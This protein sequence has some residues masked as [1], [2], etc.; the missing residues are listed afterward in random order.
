MGKTGGNLRQGM[1]NTAASKS[2][3]SI[4]QKRSGK[5]PVNPNHNANLISYA[6]VLGLSKDE[7]NVRMTRSKAIKAAIQHNLLETASD[8][9]LENLLREAIQERSVEKAD[10]LERI[11][12]IIGAVFREQGSGTTAM[13][14]NVSSND[15]LKPLS[16]KFVDAQEVKQDNEQSDDGHQG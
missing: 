8:A 12:R 6:D 4:Q 10:L 2:R 3:K 15:P 11:C 5:C 9:G 7:W 1:A 14:V 16:F 13:Q